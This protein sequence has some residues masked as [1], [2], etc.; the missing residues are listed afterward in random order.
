[1]PQQPEPEIW[2]APEPAG[3]EEEPAA[4][5][6]EP[7]AQHFEAPAA[8]LHEEPADE[9]YDEHDEE[10]EEEEEGEEVEA[11]DGD[12]QSLARLMKR[13]ESGLSGKQQALVAPPPAAVAA[14]EPDPPSAGK[15]RPPPAQRH[16][17]SRQD[18]GARPL[19]AG[20]PGVQPFRRSFSQ[21]R[22]ASRIPVAVPTRRPI[23]DCPTIV[24][25]TAPAMIA[26]AR[27]APPAWE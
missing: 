21:I 2:H 20:R 26:I 10:A 18:F 8:W 17:R 3:F 4:L 13:F 11:S 9:I 15:G 25:A 27:M 6:E 1:M 19:T 24:P 5:A 23:V 7:V 16:L 14:A 12:D 22:M